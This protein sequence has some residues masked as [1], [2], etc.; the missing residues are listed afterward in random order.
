MVI[1]SGLQ[2]NVSGID[3]NVGF[4]YG[5]FHI[6]KGNGEFFGN[7]NLINVQKGWYAQGDGLIDGLVKA[8]DMINQT[9]T[10][11]LPKKFKSGVSYIFT[12]E[13]LTP[14]VSNTCFPSGTPITTDQGNIAIEKINPKNHTIR[15]KKIVAVTETVSLDT[16]LICFE[17]NSLG[18]NIPCER[19]QISKNHVIYYKGKGR[20][21]E[22]FVGRVENVRNV[23]YNGEILYNILQ[24]EH[25]KMMVNNIIVETL[26]PSNIIAQ[27]YSKNYNFHG[28]EGSDPASPGS[29]PAS[30]GSD[31][32]SSGSDPAS[33]G[34]EPASSGSEPASP[35]S[36]P[37]SPGS[38]PASSGS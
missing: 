34:S 37:A 25:D 5:G 7:S 29:E 23:K 11:A 21:A 28:E 13:R 20:K 18:N 32:A 27:I 24:E 3:T 14:F 6:D 22:Y 2:Q 4:F 15:K 38:E 35:G 17:K 31:P 30:P 10:I 36:E 1:Y 16:H 12:S 26:H 33:P 9:I 8:V 19:T